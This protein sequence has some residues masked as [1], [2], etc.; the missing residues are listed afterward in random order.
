LLRDVAIGGGGFSTVFSVETYSGC[1]QP[2]LHFSNWHA[3]AG[4]SRHYIF[5]LAQDPGEVRIASSQLA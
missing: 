5:K 3:A 4:D 2:L 1:G